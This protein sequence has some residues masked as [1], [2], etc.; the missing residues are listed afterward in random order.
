MDE[1]LFITAVLGICSALLTEASKRTGIKIKYLLVLPVCFLATVYVLVQQYTP[2]HM[3][4]EWINVGSKILASAVLF[5][6]FI[7]VRVLKMFPNN[8]QK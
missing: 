3:V 5:Y 6:E 7:L 2:Q 4:Q 8:E 1:S